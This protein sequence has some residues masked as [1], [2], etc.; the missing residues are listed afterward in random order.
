MLGLSLG[1]GLGAGLAGYAPPVIP[2][3]FGGVTASKDGST[4]QTYTAPAGMTG[5][6]WYREVLTID[7]TKTLIG[8]ATASTYI[9]QAADEFYRPVA[10]GMVD[11][12]L[13]DAVSLHVVYPPP[14][15]LEPFESLTG[16]AASAGGVIALATD[17]V[18]Y[19]TNRL[20]LTSTGTASAQATK[21]SI[22]SFDPS[23]LGTIA[24]SAD[25]GMDQGRQ[26]VQNHRVVL[27]RDGVDHYLQAVTTTGTNYE[28]PSPLH[29]GKL[30]GG[31]HVSEVAGLATAG[32]SNM[33][34]YVRQS[35]SIPYSQE[36]KYDALLGKAGGRPTVILGF[37]DNKLT[38]Y[39]NAF[40]IMQARGMVGIF[41]V[42]EQLTRNSSFMTTAMLQEM[43]AAG[44][45]CGLDST[46]N[47]DIS[48]SFGTMAA[49]EASFQ[50][51]R[52][53]AIANGMTRGN[54]H[55]AY[56]H[57][58][59]ENNPPSDRVSVAAVTSDGTAAVTMESTTGIA[60]GMRAVGHQIPNSPV[61]TVLTVD[62]ATQVTLS[63]NVPAQTKPVLFV[64]E[65]PEFYTMK[66]PKRVAALGIRTARTTRSQ[67]GYIS[68]FGFGDRGMFTFAQALHNTTYANFVA[69]IDRAILRGTTIEWYTH[70]VFAGGTGTESDI[71]DF[72]QKMDYL[73]LKRDQGLLDVMTWSQVWARDGNATVPTGLASPPGGPPSNIAYVS[74]SSANTTPAA[75]SGQ[76]AGDLLLAFAYKDGASPAPSLPAGWTTVSS[77]W[78]NNS[79]FLLAYR[80]ATAD[81]ET[82]P[83]FTGAT[84]VL[85]HCYRGASGVGNVSA[86]ATGASGSATI[87]GGWAL[88]GS[89]TSWVAY[90]GGVRSASSDLDTVANRIG[91]TNATSTSDAG[92]NDTGGPVTTTGSLTAGNSGGSTWHAVAVEIKA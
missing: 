71:V 14:V 3:N 67:E 37:D 44:W 29:I 53:Y 38:Q 46:H 48:S 81:A 87:P 91:H 57:G 89:G 54:E 42:P 32:V 9:A 22:G 30:W 16:W 85:V 49:W 27:R 17:G 60:A 13:T 80:I 73:A 75:P 84:N 8:G 19:G 43:Y 63:A 21:A 90:F 70:G 23:L 1:L 52:D 78:V 62:S 20:Q 40:P 59:I 31:Y 86:A 35:G 24:F 15:I 41:Y 61:T 55:I 5:V 88:Q 11:G 74:G 64:D 82:I 45:D 66:L 50:L 25:L 6:Q 39:T 34:L 68:R 18:D 51:N 7:R 28:T 58:Q 47:D 69:I 83:A 12:V 72:T 76:V 10:R 56:T 4:G 2:R 36:T 79:G 33:G 92:G 26:S 77:D 65:A